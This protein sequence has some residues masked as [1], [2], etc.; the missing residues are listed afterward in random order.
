M[1]IIKTLFVFVVVMVLGLAV[2]ISVFG[3]SDAPVS[4]A[5]FVSMLFETAGEPAVNNAAPFVDVPAGA[6]YSGAVSW[7]AQYNIVT[8]VGGGIFSPENAVTREQAAVMMLNYARYQGSGP[9]GAWAVRLDY[10]DLTDISEWAFQGVMYAKIHG[11][12]P[13]KQGNLFDPKGNMTR[14]EAEA[15]LEK[16]AEATAP[17]ALAEKAFTYFLEVSKVPRVSG[18]MQGISDFFKAFGEE[19]SLETI[20]DEWLNILIK[21]PGSPGRENEPPVILQAHMDMVGEK[22]QGTPHDFLKDPIIPIIDGDWVTANGTTLGAD[23]GAGLAMIMAVLDS[24]SLSHPPIEALLTADEETT[25]IGALEFDVSLLTGRRLINLDNMEEGH[26]VVSCASTNR[27]ELHIP[28]ETMPLPDGF[29]TYELSIKGLNGG[30]SGVDIHKGLANANI[31]MER[32]LG[33]F[34]NIPLFVSSIDG[35]SAHNAIPRE[36][37]AVLSIDNLDLNAVRAIIEQ[38]EILFKSEF[39]LDVN[40]TVSFAEIQAAQYVMTVA[41]FKKVSEG[42]TRMPNGV[43]SMSPDIEGLVQTSNN[44]GVIAAGGDT[45]MLVGFVR[46]SSLEGRSQTL[47]A[48]TALA[49]DLGA[50]LEVAAGN[51]PWPYRA[52][53][54]LRDTMVELFTQTFNREP[55]IVAIHAGLE[56]AAFAHNMPDCDMIAIGPD[57]RRE[58]TPDERMSLSSFYRTTDFLVRALQTL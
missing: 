10:A 22:N 12:L 34:G 43:L 1:R 39:P 24:D 56:C 2:T 55:V 28:I 25:M 6:S 11:L 27:V 51:L 53:S 8:G 32:L 33:E 40:L 13:E 47:E 16:L 29:T 21:K 50:R 42:I 19:R 41:S 49:Y 54:P 7:A 17:S 48:I 38:T 30:H 52:D 14:A 23:N 44:L 20:Q 9:V 58:H 36:C 26:F 45:V 35:G 15:A 57:I 46:S 4:R 37:T 31:L 18:N 5:G 3:Q